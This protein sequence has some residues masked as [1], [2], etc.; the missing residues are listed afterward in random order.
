LKTE[1]RLCKANAAL[2]DV[3][4]Q[5]G[6]GT[7]ENKVSY[8]RIWDCPSL[9]PKT[10]FKYDPGKVPRETH[11]RAFAV[12][13]SHGARFAIDEIYLFSNLEDAQTFYSRDVTKEQFTDGHGHLIGFQCVT[14][15][16]TTLGT[17]LATKCIPESDETE[18]MSGGA[19]E[20][21]ESE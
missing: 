2:S 6:R 3:Y 11:D 1:K 18:V 20:S 17:T 19:D 21:R 16:E 10:W 14:L 13:V 15:F 4:D 8:D 5:V 9:D 7:G 12:S